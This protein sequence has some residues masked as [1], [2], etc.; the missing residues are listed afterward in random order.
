M[1]ICAG[2]SEA[3]L[4]THTT[5]LEISCRHSYISTLYLSAMYPSLIK[6][7]SE[8]PSSCRNSPA[9]KESQTDERKTC[10]C[11]AAKNISIYLSAT[12]SSLIKNRS[13]MPSSCKNSPAVKGSQTD[14]RK[15][16]CC[17]A[18]KIYISTYLSATFSSLIAT[19]AICQ[20]QL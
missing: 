5:L 9:V 19:G 2:W 14:E 10:C 15:T 20:G 1:P 12:F 11:L 13:D 17:L 8:F 7:R 4:V 6:H 16:C 18:T 3:L